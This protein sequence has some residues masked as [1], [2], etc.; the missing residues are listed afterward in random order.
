MPRYNYKC[1]A[2]GH[3]FS[4]STIISKRKLPEEGQCDECGE[5]RIKMQM[6]APQVVSGVTVEDKIPQG[7]KDVMNNIKKTSGKDCTIDV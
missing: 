3:A 2:C 4:V 5:T 6:S 1:G 7:F